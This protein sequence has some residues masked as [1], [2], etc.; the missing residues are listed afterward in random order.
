MHGRSVCVPFLFE[1]YVAHYYHVNNPPKIRKRDSAIDLAHETITQIITFLVLFSFPPMSRLTVNSV[2]SNYS[3]YTFEGVAWDR[4]GHF[5]SIWIIDRQTYIYHIHA[6]MLFVT[7][8]TKP[9]DMREHSNLLN[10]KEIGGIRVT[11][12]CTRTGS[13]FL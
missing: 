4:D 1:A 10:A 5:Q 9:L 8:Q 6:Y 11:K 2:S 3:M 12:M 13:S 7:L